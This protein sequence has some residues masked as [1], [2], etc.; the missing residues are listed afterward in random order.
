MVAVPPSRY[1]NAK[2]GPIC[3]EKKSAPCPVPAGSRAREGLPHMDQCVEN[4]FVDMSV[5]FLIR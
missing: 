2:A 5:Y 3:R 4:F 1:R